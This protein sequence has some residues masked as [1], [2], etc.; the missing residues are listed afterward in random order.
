[1]FDGG[2]LRQSGS[3]STQAGEPARSETNKNGGA[4]A[5][6][7]IYLDPGGSRGEGKTRS[8]T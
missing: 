4:V 6:H 8:R 3:A 2:V 7:A 5:P 1:M